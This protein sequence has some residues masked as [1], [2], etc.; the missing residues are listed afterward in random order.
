M[1][2]HT[3]THTHT[4]SLQ[5]EL[6]RQEQLR[7]EEEV[8]EKA[9]VSGSCFS[10]IEMC[11]IWSNW[12]FQIIR[13][14]QQKI[15]DMRKELV[16]W[17]FYH[18]ISFIFTLQISLLSQQRSQSTVDL[19]D[20]SQ[21]QSGSRTAPPRPHPPNNRKER[22]VSPPPRIAIASDVNFQYPMIQM[23][24]LIFVQTLSTYLVTPHLQIFEI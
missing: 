23:K 22:S 5:L 3:H 12:F 14:Q 1:K 18:L 11:L 4:P 13:L 16:S 6:L 7:L 21:V 9:K 2:I 17:K 24:I 8:T 20:L 15:V 10:P 19:S